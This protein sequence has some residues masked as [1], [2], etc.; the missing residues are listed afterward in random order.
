MTRTYKQPSPSTR[1]AIASIVRGTVAGALGMLAMDA[2]LYRGYRQ[3]NG[4]G[5][6]FDWESSAGLDSWESAPAPALVA[7]RLLEATLGREIS[8]RHGRLLNNATHWGFGLANGAAY[9][10]F[11]SR[12]TPNPWA[13]IPFGAAVWASGYVV[14]PPL[15]VYE[16][17]WRYDAATLR[18]DLTAHLV[19]GTATG[20]AVSL[21]ARAERARMTTRAR[22]SLHHTTRK[23]G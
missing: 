20:A 6:F 4:T 10:L 8:P 17:I 7:K 14:L 16:P 2:W 12:N 9:G 23:G 5:A 19:F 22:R 15:G 1:Q 3:R 13:G 11:G 18:A 21:L